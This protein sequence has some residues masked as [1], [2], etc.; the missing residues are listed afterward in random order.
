MIKSTC[1]FNFCA[2]PSSPSTCIFSL[3][4]Y[5]IIMAGEMTSSLL[6]KVMGKYLRRKLTH[7]SLKYVAGKHLRRE[8]KMFVE[9]R[10]IFVRMSY[11]I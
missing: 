2:E 11:N 5:S 8:R 3:G 7:T 6:R 10:R 9:C 1:V 4:E